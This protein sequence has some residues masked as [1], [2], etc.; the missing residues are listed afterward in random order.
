MVCDIGPP[1]AER[2]LLETSCGSSMWGA[3]SAISCSI[4]GGCSTKGLDPTGRLLVPAVPWG[5]EAVLFA[6]MGI[7]A[8]FTGADAT[9]TQLGRWILCC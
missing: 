6:G 8:Q 2:Q 5:A 1:T 3:G 9:E 7:G 4:R